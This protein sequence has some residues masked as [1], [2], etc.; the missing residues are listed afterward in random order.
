MNKILLPRNQFGKTGTI[1]AKE[2]PNLR[3]GHY[4]LD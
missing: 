2:F 3:E 4:E 1:S